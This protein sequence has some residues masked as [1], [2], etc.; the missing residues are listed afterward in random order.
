MENN[1]DIESEIKSKDLITTGF[2][3]ED[4]MK[5]GFTAEQIKEMYEDRLENRI[6]KLTKHSS[7]NC[8]LK[9]EYLKK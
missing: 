6:K 7:Y 2:R 3:V 1:D 5:I 4:I 8:L 9:N